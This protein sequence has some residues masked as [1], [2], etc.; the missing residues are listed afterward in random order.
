M[1]DPIPEPLSGKHV[2]DWAVPVTRALNA[3][4]DKA[5]AKARN[6]RDRRPSRQPLPFE[7]RWSSSANNGAGA[8]VIWLPDATSLVHIGNAY[9]SPISN[10]VAEAALPAGWFR[11]S[12]VT[13]TSTAVW[14]NITTVTQTGQIWLD[15]SNSA[16]QSATGFVCVPLLIA[17][18]TTDAQT[19]SRNVKQ[20]IDST[21]TFGGSS[22][23]GGGGLTGTVEFV[24]DVDWYVNGSVHQL[25]KRLRV[26][27]LATGNA[28]DK[29]NTTYANGWEVATDTTPIAA[30]IN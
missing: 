10:I 1:N 5:G 12:T 22:G 13:A 4:G 25:R 14:L 30:I 23:G 27:D 15:I 16:G 17:T 8:W 26:L 19:S 6:E 20:F 24:A 29:A 7:V 28:T 9:I 3:L 21:I 18:M 11:M 2:L